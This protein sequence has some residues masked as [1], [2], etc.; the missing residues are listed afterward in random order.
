MAEKTKAELLASTPIHLREARAKGTPALG[1][2]AVFPLDIET[3]LVDPF[4]LPSFWWYIGGLDFGWDHPTAAVQLAHDRDSD[5]VYVV[6]DYRKS[7]AT[8]LVHSDAVKPWGAWLPW[9]W[10]H[11]GLQHDKG[12]SCEQL[13]QQYRDRGLNMLPQHAQFVDGTNGVESGILEMLDRMIAGKWK[14]FKTCGAWRQEFG[15]YHRKDGIIVKKIDDAISASRYAYM[16]LRYAKQRPSHL[17][18][19]AQRSGIRSPASSAGY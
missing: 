11:D 5:I 4:E 7:Q 12:G 2:G 13:A 9:A 19:M 14:V 6:K 17:T 18:G 8:P 16:M 3:I 1:S 10:P 15:L